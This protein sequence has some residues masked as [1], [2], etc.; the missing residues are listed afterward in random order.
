MIKNVIKQESENFDIQLI[1]KE[2][3]PG[4]NIQHIWKY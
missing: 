2:E 1:H 3:Y 4:E